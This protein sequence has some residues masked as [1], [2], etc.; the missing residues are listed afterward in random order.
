MGTGERGSLATGGESA[1]DPRRELLQRIAASPA[2][3]KS[4]RLRDFLIYVGERALTDPDNS[5]RE[6]EVGVAVFGWTPGQ[7]YSEDTVVRVQAS[8]LRKKLQLYFATEGAGES[9]RIDIPRG[10]YMPVFFEREP[11]VDGLPGAPAAPGRDRHDRRLI[12]G[13]GGLSVALFVCC[14]WLG[15][16]C[17]GL[18]HRLSDGLALR[19]NVERL[20]RQM[21]GSAGDAHVVLADSNL[22]IL[23][24]LMRRQMGLANYQRRQFSTEAERYIESPVL[25]DMALKVMNREYTHIGDAILVRQVAL[26][27]ASVGLTTDIV[28]ARDAGPG[29]F[30]GHNAILSGPRRANPWV[31]LFEDRLNFRSEFDEEKRQSSLVNLAPQ[32]GEASRYVATWNHE[33]FCHVAYLPNLD[34]TGSV[35]VI[36][37]TEMSASAAGAEFITSEDWVKQLYARLGLRAGQRIPHFEVLLRTQLVLSAA[38]RFELIAHRVIRP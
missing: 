12:L 10:S 2:F 25:R 16:S 8:Q 4:R 37:G 5:V 17:L 24:D 15:A 11:E 21:F 27:A 19:P 28:F 22:T 30:S 18:R 9:L 3:Q 36:S 23:H 7:D 6:H 1:S 34:R 35:L 29:D 26:T 38:P 14:A 20:W 31:E 32:A 33:G 13:L